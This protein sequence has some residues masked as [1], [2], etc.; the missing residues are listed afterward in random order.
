MTFRL[1]VVLLVLALFCGVPFWWFYLDGPFAGG[2]TAIL[3]VP[4][5]RVLAGSQPDG[6]I[7]ISVTDVGAAV[8]SGNLHA[9][10]S[11]IRRRE[12]DVLSF[13]LRYRDGRSV[14]IG[15]GMSR[16]TALA[17]GL[18]YYSDGKQKQVE[19]DI[20][21]ATAILAT[22]PGVFDL[23]G[24][25]AMAT[26]PA[27]AP[28]LARARLSQGQLPGPG[29]PADVPWPDGLVLRPA[30]TGKVPRPVLPGVVAIPADTVEAGNLL[31][32]V[33]LASGREYV[34]A[35]PVAPFRVSITERRARSRLLA[36][37]GPGFDRSAQMAWLAALRRA[38][39][40]YPGLAVIP[41]N[42]HAWIVDRNARTGIL[43]R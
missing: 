22:G 26:D 9:A 33:R 16:Q 21:A 2:H 3:G 42:D 36:S 7:D 19:G 43:S 28:A 32:Y 5:L 1:N 30:I 12:L 24:L 20:R 29:A 25:A 13:R 11:G 15:T 37:E 34:L 39:R 40:L 17:S 14:V 38:E 41:G 8:H 4:A 31:I 18:R 10:G 23:G 27:A 35:G 6:P